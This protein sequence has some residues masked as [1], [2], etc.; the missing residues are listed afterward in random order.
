MNTD[1][2]SVKQAAVLVI[3]C[4]YCLKRWGAALPEHVTAVCPL[5]AFAHKGHKTFAEAGDCECATGMPL[6]REAAVAASSIA[7]KCWC[8]S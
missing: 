5:S 4:Q 7:G 3:A 1:N 8:Q 2:T 6:Q